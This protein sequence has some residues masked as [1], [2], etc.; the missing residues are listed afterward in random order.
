VER[1]AVVVAYDENEEF[2]TA[3]YRC[4]EGFTLKGKSEITCDLDTDEW[5]EMPP[6]CEPGKVAFHHES[7]L[8]S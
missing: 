1:A 5:L 3:S 7:R 2:V 6:T 8:A 4:Q